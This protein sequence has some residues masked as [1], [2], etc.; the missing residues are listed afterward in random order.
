MRVIFMGTPEFAVPILCA[1]DS[2]HDVVAVFTQPDR[3][4]GRGRQL[5]PSPVKVA[6]MDRGLRLEQP[7]SLHEPG[8]LDTL[9]ELQPELI[10]VAAYGGILPR[11][12]LDIP[13]RG[14][15]NVHASLLPRHRG[16]APVHRAILEGDDQVGVVIMQMEEGLDTGPFTEVR[17]IPSAD[18]SVTT[19]TSELSEL[20]AEALLDAIRKIESGT[21]E[22]TVQD[23][24]CATYAEKITSTDVRIE[25]ALTVE[26]AL[27]RIRAS[28]G[29]ARSAVD[30]GGRTVQ[31][32]AAEPSPRSVNSGEA[33]IDDCEL[34]LGLSD[35]ALRVAELKPQ[36]K[37]AMDAAGFVRG[38]QIGPTC[39]WTSGL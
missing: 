22:W 16:A 24:A 20:G 34:F 21:V 17:A 8:V 29:S 27:R 10:C 15:L 13:P 26:Q 39:G 4:R 3:P 18:K 37:R 31:I 5:T 23:E 32:L 35:G 2:E 33:L 28:T 7:T 25:P 19:L 9:N 30:L 38:A 36:G 14:C 1:L 6:A 11:E 12:I